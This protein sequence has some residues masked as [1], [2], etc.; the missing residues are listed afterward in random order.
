LLP[1]E[2]LVGISDDD[3]ADIIG[4]SNGPAYRKTE[5]RT[6]PPLDYV[7]EKLEG[8]LVACHEV[9]QSMREYL[10]DEL[11]EPAGSTERALPTRKDALLS[12]ALL[13][14]RYALVSYL[15]LY[16]LLNLANVPGLAEQL[17]AMEPTK[18]RQWLD[19]VTTEGS[20]TG[21]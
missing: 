15:A 16:N 1:Q 20:V 21:G 9:L 7:G 18:F 12:P 5:E 19:N 6:G 4:D 10:P 2:V 11:P 17:A 3:L 8:A 14:F 13:A